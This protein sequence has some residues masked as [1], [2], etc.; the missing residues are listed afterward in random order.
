MTD[1][2][3]ILEHRAHMILLQLLLL[4]HQVGQHAGQQRRLPLNPRPAG[5]VG[6]GSGKL[7]DAAHHTL[8]MARQRLLQQQTH[9]IHTS[10]TSE[11]S[12]ETNRVSLNTIQYGTIRYSTVQYSTVQV[13][14][15]C[16]VLCCIGIYCTIQHHQYNT[17]QYTKPKHNGMIGMAWDN[18]C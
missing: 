8:H 9:N 4:H 13:K 17:A 15:W 3:H 14:V 12:A 16:V 6:A 7:G 11:V 18:T 10:Y 5:M 1:L 2:R